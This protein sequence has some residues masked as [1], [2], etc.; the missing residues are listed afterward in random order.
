MNFDVNKIRGIAR[1]EVS[2]SARFMALLLCAAGVWIASSWFSGMAGSASSSLALSQ[3][4]YAELNRLAAEYK[5]LA[6]DSA[7]G[8]EV[9]VMTAFAQVS[10]RIELGNRVTRISP[11]MD[12]TRCFVEIN[13]L[14][15][16]ELTDMVREL[17]V[18]GIKIITA[19]IFTIPVGEERLFRLSF[20][21]GAEA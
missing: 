18:R 4:R 12:G 16:E 3:T 8:G 9:D 13:R 15:A 7:S 20:T 14:Y 1:G 21:I 11:M 6:P 2:G 17:G 19:E 10:A 5:V